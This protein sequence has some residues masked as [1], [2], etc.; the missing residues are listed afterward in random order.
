M[1]LASKRE[2]LGLKERELG[3]GLNFQKGGFEKETRTSQE[4][5]GIVPSNEIDGLRHLLLNGHLSKEVGL[6]SNVTSG[7]GNQAESV[8]GETTLLR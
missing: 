7:P 6:T 8:E 5:N 1:S 4:L 2:K 3:I